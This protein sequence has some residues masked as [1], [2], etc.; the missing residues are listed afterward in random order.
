MTLTVYPH[1]AKHNNNN[2]A[3]SITYVSD[4]CYPMSPVSPERRENERTGLVGMSE[5]V[6]S[7]IQGLENH[8]THLFEGLEH[9]DPLSGHG[10]ERSETSR[11]QLSFQHL[12]WGSR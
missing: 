1:I 10:L 4:T 9:T 2:H 8:F 3:K 11:I 12:N 7:L 6:I 5:C